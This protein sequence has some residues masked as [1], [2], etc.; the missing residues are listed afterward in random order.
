[1]ICIQLCAVEVDCNRGAVMAA[2]LANGGYCPITENKVCICLYIIEY[3]AKTVCV[4]G[5]CTCTCY[6][7]IVSFPGLPTVQIWLLAV[8]KAEF[9]YYKQLKIGAGEGLGMRLG[10]AWEWSQYVYQARQRG[11]WPLN[12]RTHITHMFFVLY[13]E[14]QPCNS[15]TRMDAGRKGLKHALSLKDPSPLC[16]LR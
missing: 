16:L 4:Y 1:M 2:T 3:Q 6:I 8:C 9:A 13:N 10:K 15:N 7:I 12:K 5:I 14:W 11:E